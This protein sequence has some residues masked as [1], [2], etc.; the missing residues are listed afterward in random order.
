[1]PLQKRLQWLERFHQ[2]TPADR[3]TLQ[4]LVAAANLAFNEKRVRKK[5][6][7]C[8]ADGVWGLVGRTQMHPVH[9]HE[10]AAF[11]YLHDGWTRQP[12]CVH[13]L[14]RVPCHHQ[15][16]TG[17]PHH[18]RPAV[19]VRPGPVGVAVPVCRGLRDVRH[20]CLAALPRQRHGGGPR[21]RGGAQHAGAARGA[22]AGRQDRP[23]RHHCGANEGA[24]QWT[25][26][27]KAR[28]QIARPAK[29]RSRAAAGC[30][31]CVQAA[32]ATRAEVV[33]RLMELLGGTAIMVGHGLHHDMRALKLDYWPVI[34]TASVF[35]FTGM[36]R[37]HTPGLAALCTAVLGR[38]LR[39]PGAPH[40]ARAD[41][42][43][44]LQLAL[45]AAHGATPLEVT[46]PETKAAPE[47]LRRLLV[48]NIPTAVTREQL[49]D[50]FA[51][52]GTLEESEDARSR[53]RCMRTETP[54]VRTGADRLASCGNLGPRARSSRR[55]ASACSCVLICACRG[56]A[57][58]CD[59][60]IRQRGGLGVSEV[61]GQGE[62]RLG[63]NHD[64]A[65]AA[66]GRRKGQGDGAANAGT[67]WCD[68]AGGAR[69]QS[70]ESECAC[71]VMGG[72]LRGL[73]G[74]CVPWD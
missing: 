72:P 23:A 54:R 74:W 38:A 29:Q 6:T 40:D 21:W 5:V 35:T 59:V 39:E 69:R 67:Q 63:G 57:D 13:I 58:L 26:V 55:S 70:A 7:R 1:M 68:D 61:P 2:G 34:D 11:P 14:K 65:G 48:H 46:P 52:H 36:P 22:S 47:A 17:H 27:Y 16:H 64:Q 24:L 33:K 37:S 15:A 9:K 73:A 53:V 32:P 43:A 49:Q 30:V 31:V 3:K 62:P 66:R 56:R 42:S 8:G 45:R 4:N 28:L 44:A 18:H 60:S 25:R 20:L 51:P 41:A 50:L 19:Q 10:Y 71:C 12:R